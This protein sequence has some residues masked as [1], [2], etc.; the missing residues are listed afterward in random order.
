[1]TR[2]RTRPH[3]AASP[4]APV[5][6]GPREINAPGISLPL[7]LPRDGGLTPVGMV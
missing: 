1:M 6:T 5:D 3:R 7:A 4:F 2:S